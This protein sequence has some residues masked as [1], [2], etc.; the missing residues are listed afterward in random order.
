MVLC[1]YELRN[2]RRGLNSSI[3]LLKDERLCPRCLPSILRRQEDDTIGAFK[4]GEKT[5]ANT[6]W[7]LAVPHDM[8][9]SRLSSCIAQPT[10]HMMVKYDYLTPKAQSRE[11]QDHHSYKHSNGVRTIRFFLH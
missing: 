5:R 8:F 2:P 3:C 6:D 9:H 11:P 7:L 4:Q 10:M 1:H